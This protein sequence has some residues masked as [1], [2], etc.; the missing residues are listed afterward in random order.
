MQLKTA[1]ETVPCICRV[2]APILLAPQLAVH[3]QGPRVVYTDYPEGHQ[4]ILKEVFPDLGQGLAEWDEGVKKDILHVGLMLQ[5]ELDM[6]VPGACELLFCA[7]QETVRFQAR[8]Q[9]SWN[10]YKINLRL[11][12]LSS[13]HFQGVQFAFEHWHGYPARLLCFKQDENTHYIAASK[14]SSLLLVHLVN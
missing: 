3:V 10:L 2:C 1:H 8:T 9:L 11:L 14:S 7:Q 12:L 6:A 13:I 4:R 5:R